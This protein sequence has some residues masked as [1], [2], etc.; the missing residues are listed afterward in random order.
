MEKH[1]S[2]PQ[3]EVNS[4]KDLSSGFL[5][6]QDIAEYL[7]VRVS[8][9]YSMVEEKKVPHYRIGRQIRFKKS[10]IDAWMEKQKEEVIDVK[11]EARRVITS[12]QNKPDLAINE[13]V[14]KAIDGAGKKRYT[15]RH[16]KP[17]LIKGL[18]KEVGDGTF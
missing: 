13:I 10:E 12:P 17:D 9:V 18:R 1:V 16:G 7:K 2:E 4:G 3:D 11:V 5:N 8:T 6:V 14:Q 15:S